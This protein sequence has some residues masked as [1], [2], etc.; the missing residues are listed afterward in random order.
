[1]K[2]LETK[3]IK[4][5]DSPMGSGKTSA[6]I[7]L[8][9]ENSNRKYIFVTPYL[10]EGERITKA[11][12]K[13]SFKDPGLWDEE[14]GV[15]NKTQHVTELL[16]RGEN[17]VTTHVLFGLFN[18]EIKEILTEQHYTLILDEVLSVIDK[19]GLTKNDW[20]TLFD[21]GRVEVDEDGLISAVNYDYV[22]GDM[23]FPLKDA[24][25]HND[26]YQY[27]GS[28]C[29]KV[30]RIDT[31]QFF[32][33][34]YVLTYMFEAQFQCALFKMN[35]FEYEC[36]GVKKDVDGYSFTNDPEKYHNPLKGIKNKIEIMDYGKNNSIG[37]GKY[38]LS[39][40]WYKKDLDVR[41]HKRHALVSRKAH[42][43]IRKGFCNNRR[44]PKE[45]LM[46]TCFESSAELLYG[47]SLKE[48][49]FVACNTRAANTWGDKT[50][51]L[52]LINRFCDPNFIN[53][54]SNR[55]ISI[56]QDDYAL[57]E[58]VQWIWRSAIRNGKEIKIY[59]PSSRMR[60]L[61]ENWIEKVN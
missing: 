29:V 39:A 15:C 49:N 27:T 10:T 6:A 57:S 55:H 18:D 56:N 8:M 26:V 30:S 43:L 38:D 47:D 24:L 51:L 41:K 53:F 59:I 19:I 46:W 32:E 13:M 33:S 60:G 35:G 52:Y 3:K 4:V 42:A 16:R 44:T 17:V 61:L 37:D 36:I 31:F 20:Q 40:E 21:T 5:V 45:S 11:C 12:A 58:M 48:E 14:I 25:L 1:M 34:V 28:T 50:N 54:F 23:Y 7:R 9:N 2:D 22:R